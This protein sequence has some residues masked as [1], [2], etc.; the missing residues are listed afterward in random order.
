MIRTV[1]LRKHYKMGD[2][3]VRALDGVDLHIAPGEFVSITGASGSGKSTLMHILGCLDRPTSGTVHVDGQHTTGLT[4]R[5]LAGLRNR[6]IGFVFQTFNLMSRTTAIDNVMLPLVYSR[7]RIRRRM[8]EEALERV[9]LK[10]RT[11]HRPSELS[12]GECQRVAIARAIVNNPKIILADEPTGNLDSRTGE[13]IMGIFHELH[14][15]GITIVLVTHEMDVAVQAARTIHMRD[16][17]IMEDVAVDVAFRKRVMTA[18]VESQHRLLKRPG[19]GDR[20]GPEG[21]ADPVTPTAEFR[22]G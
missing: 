19:D 7:G 22:K 16:G 15:Q 1:Q 9:G 4:G 12:G 11:R 18:A 20:H 3:V 10:G 21:G 17:R 5:Q 13:Q 2:S 6:S 14:E 8:A